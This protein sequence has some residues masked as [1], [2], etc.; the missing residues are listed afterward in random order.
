MYTELRYGLNNVFE[1]RIHLLN[2]NTLTRLEAEKLPW[3]VPNP[4]L[5]LRLWTGTNPYF[6]LPIIIF[7][8]HFIKPCVV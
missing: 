2:A 7:P 1:L 8:S 6:P 3:V 5:E 4:G